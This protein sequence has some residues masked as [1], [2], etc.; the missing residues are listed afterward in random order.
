MCKIKFAH[1]LSLWDNFKVPPPP[2]KVK[3][4]LIFVKNELIFSNDFAIHYLLTFWPKTGVSRRWRL[5]SSFFT[6][7][8]KISLQYL[9]CRIR[10]N[11][12][13]WCY[14]SRHLWLMLLDW[15]FRNNVENAPT[16]ALIFLTGKITSKQ[17]WAYQKSKTQWKWK[18]KCR[19]IYQNGNK[20][21][22]KFW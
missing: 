6:S 11:L 1:I 21:R 14:D 7:G 2:P 17:F 12:K 16:K 13:F 15:G 4:C 5:N 3:I 9:I 10:N 19:H 22:R 8:I 18:V 20:N